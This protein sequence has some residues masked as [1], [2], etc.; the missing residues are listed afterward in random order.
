MP[1]ITMVFFGL[2]ALAYLLI[3]A[4]TVTGLLKLA[5]KES[6]TLR[7]IHKFA[8]P[9]AIVLWAMVVYGA[10]YA[11][12]GK[13]AMLSLLFTLFVSLTF[14]GGITGW[15]VKEGM[16][17]ILHMVLGGLTFGLFT[18]FIFGVMLAQA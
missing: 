16:R 8:V 3:L 14:A 10:F 5:I 15:L 7:M 17:R 18:Y 6:A 2:I 11:M 9:P 1:N 4:I 12:P 13:P